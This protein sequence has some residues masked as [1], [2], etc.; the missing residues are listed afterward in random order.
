MPPCAVASPRHLDWSALLQGLSI[1]CSRCHPISLI[2]SREDG[3]LGEVDGAGGYGGSRQPVAGHLVD[4]GLAVLDAERF[5]RHSQGVWLAEGGYLDGDG[6]G[7]QKIAFAAVDLHQ[8][9]RASRRGR[10]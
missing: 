8:I 7:G 4:V 9:G 6:G 1:G 5:T 10:G 2:E 3:N